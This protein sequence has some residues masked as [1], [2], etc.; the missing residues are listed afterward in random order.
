MSELTI[1]V[2]VYNVRNVLER[3]VNSLLN[4]TLQD[5]EIILVD[6]GSIDGSGAICDELKKKDERI[7]VIH[8]KNEGAGSARNCGIAVAKSEYIT[9]F[10]A[11]DF[12]K[13]SMYK[14]MLNQMIQNQTDLIIC[15]YESIRISIDNS[16]EII[17]SQNVFNRIV[18]GKSDVREMWFELRKLNISLLNTPWNKIY[19]RNIILDNNIRFPNLRRAQ[20]AVFN[21]HYYDKIQSLSVVNQQYYQYSLNDENLVGKKFPKDAYQCFYYLDHVMVE[22][23]KSWGMYFGEYKALCDNHLIGIIDECVALCDNP[24]W[25]FTKKEKLE[26]LSKI[27]SDNEVLEK[28]KHY[29]GYVSEL[30]DLLPAFLKKNPKAVLCVVQ[31]R[32]VKLFL[33]NSFIGIIWRLIKRKFIKIDN[34]G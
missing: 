10:D 6:D 18:Y 12:A 4:Q 15:S 32:K 13:P 8:K 25:G 19:R 2:P 22:T 3:G 24:V 33:K 28:V 16:I 26:Y 1:V 30:E 29:Q 7:K 34:C 5:L 23:I 14:S 21:M 27:M 17:N 20:D 31:K 9:F 11:D